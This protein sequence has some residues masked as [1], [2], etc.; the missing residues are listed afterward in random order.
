MSKS[1]SGKSAS[2]WIADVTVAELK[3]RLRNSTL[4]IRDVAK[5]M[6]FPNT[7]FFCQYTK[8]HTGMTPNQFRKMRRD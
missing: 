8:K 4:S 2:E 6:E 3:H 1:R 7:S 5:E